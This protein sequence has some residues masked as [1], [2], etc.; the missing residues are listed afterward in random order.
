MLRRILSVPALRPAV[1]S[2]PMRL[3]TS[4]PLLRSEPAAAAAAATQRTGERKTKLHLRF[5]TPLEVFYS[6]A[7][8]VPSKFSSNLVDSVTLPTPEGQT[9]VL[10]NHVPAMIQLAPG[11]VTIYNG[12][13]PKQ[14]FVVSG[15]FAVVKPDSTVSISAAEGVSI[16]E[17]DLDAF[18]RELEVARVEKDKATEATDKAKWQVAYEALFSYHSILS[19]FK[20]A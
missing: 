17:L 9:S 12:D 3:F 1:S 7:K 15:G 6:D 11:L 19:H 20:K 2:A 16:D 13:E 18:T 10:P 8:D 5:A 14:Q 4:Q